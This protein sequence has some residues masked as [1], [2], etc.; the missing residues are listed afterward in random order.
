MSAS[1]INAIIINSFVVVVAAEFRRPVSV[2]AVSEVAEEERED[3]TRQPRFI[4]S[5]FLHKLRCLLLNSV[6]LIRNNAMILRV[7]E[8]VHTMHTQ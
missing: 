3:E 8:M 4:F 1:S 5:F 7:L 2:S 6:A